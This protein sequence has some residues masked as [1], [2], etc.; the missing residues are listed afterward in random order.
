M[1]IRKKRIPPETWKSLQLSHI[2][3]W[4]IY[5]WLKGSTLDSVK[6]QIS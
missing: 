3:Y 2:P 5:S 1:E 6:I 4:N